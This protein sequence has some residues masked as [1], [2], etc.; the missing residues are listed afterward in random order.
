MSVAGSDELRGHAAAESDGASWHGNV[1]ENGDD[2]M[3]E[4]RLGELES[5]M[6]KNE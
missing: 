3:E 1:N 6:V 5:G 4:T 2:D